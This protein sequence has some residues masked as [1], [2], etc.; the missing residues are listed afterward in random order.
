M[1]IAPPEACI[2]CKYCE[3]EHENAVLV[4]KFNLYPFVHLTQAPAA[5]LR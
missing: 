4:V 5:Y 2:S 3:L 1:S